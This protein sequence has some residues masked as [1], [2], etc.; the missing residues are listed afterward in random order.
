M[1]DLMPFSY[2]ILFIAAEASPFAKVGGLGDVIGSLPCELRKAGHDAR[3]VLPFYATIHNDCP[4]ISKDV[5]TIPFLGKSET[6]EITEVR[7][8]ESVPFYLMGNET[9]LNRMAIYGEH[10]DGER[11]QFFSRAAMEIPRRLN[12]QPDIIHCHDWHTA[13]CAGLLKFD[14]NDDPFYAG[15]G[16]VFTIHNLAYQGWFDD[17]YIWKT[18]LHRYLL[19]P[20]DPLRGLTYSMMGIGIVHADAVTTVSETYAKEILTPEYSFGMHELLSRKKGFLCGI[21][22]GI[23]YDDFNPATNRHLAG[24]YDINNIAGK[25]KN[26][27]A[28]QKMVGLPVNTRI[29][30][31]GMAGRLVDQKG[32]EL[33]YEALQMLLPDANLQCIIQGAGDTRYKDILEKLESGNVRK[34][35]LFF[36][37]DFALADMIYGG[38]DMFL[39]PSKFEPCGLAPMIAMRFGTLPIVRYTGGMVESVP[40]CSPDLSTGLG[41]V[42]ERYDAGELATA[43]RRAL[44][45][46]EN[47]DKWAQLVARTMAA[48]YSWK[49]AISKYEAVY[50]AVKTQAAER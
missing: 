42:F 26:K 24:R 49:P 13:L 39:M 44:A 12:W 2:K 4:V 22:N 17:S 25:H 30:L 19:P 3:V 36:V 41:F 5:F 46:Y 23:D 43:I 33:A 1:M 14:Y 38:S 32:P 27:A 28:L 10:D 9:Y 7:Q 45:A 37:L 35:R 8:K 50:N 11:F 6:V 48:D 34:A 31:I 40:D 47:E 29:P 16:S 15:T 21:L 18:D 20:G